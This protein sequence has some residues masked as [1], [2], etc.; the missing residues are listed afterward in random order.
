MAFE[1][2]IQKKDGDTVIILRD[3][4]SG[5]EAE[6]FAF[7]ALLN[8]FTISSKKGKVNVIDGFTSPADARENM[9]NGFKSAKLS[10]FVCRMRNGKYT[11]QNNSYSIEGHYLGSHAI[12]GL[13][14]AGNYA[15]TGSESEDSYV[16]VHLQYKYTGTDSGYPF[17]YTLSVT[18]KLET[19]NQLTVT[20]SIHNTGTQAIP[21]ADGWHPYFTLGGIADEWELRFDSGLQ[22]EYDEELLPTGKTFADNRFEKGCLLKGI[23]LD[24]SFELQGENPVCTLSNSS[25]QLSLAPDHNYPILQLY[26]PPHRKSIAIE[27]LSGAPDNFNNHISLIT[28]Q[29]GEK[30]AFS[31]RYQLKETV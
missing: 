9:L 30:K 12:H 17:P 2:G 31:V 6:I 7:G 8:A 1:A 29:P 25:L 22:L 16:A 4:T 10:P 27:N 13:L 5:T 24:N 20:T 11:W 19:G 15:V 3:T 23:E 28:L 14:F 21:V 18:W 26:I